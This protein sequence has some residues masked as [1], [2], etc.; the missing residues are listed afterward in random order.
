MDYSLAGLKAL[1]CG[2]TQGIGR[3]CA[4]Q[5]ARAGAE[6][7]LMARHEDALAKVRDEL[8]C[9]HDQSH[10]YIVADFSDWQMVQEKANDYVST[11]GPIQILLNN[12]GGP[13]A[14]PVF[15]ATP[16][17]LLKAFTMHIVCNQVLVQALAE[18]MRK[19][20]YGRII[21]I[22]ST[23]VVAPIRGLGVSNTTRGAVANWARTLAGELGPFGI[24]VNNILPGYT[25]TARLSSL[26][27]GKA[28][29]A[30]SSVKEI[31][32]QMIANVPL[33]RFAEPLEIGAVAAFLASPEASYLNGLNLPVDGG[34]LAWQ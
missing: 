5:I 17:D 4:T 20:G 19:A 14:G 11:N 8:P 32:D 1:V 34:R 6:I 26:I 15:E 7:V 23:S 27:K 25:G 28:D 24:T 3:A 12:T 22:I 13:P 30:G 31:E 10:D 9:K 16:D 18:G 2:S 21:N 33:R 29:R